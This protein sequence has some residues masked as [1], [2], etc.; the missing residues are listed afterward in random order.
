MLLQI[1][2]A[3]QVKRSTIIGTKH[4]IYELPYELQI[5]L[6]LWILKIREGQEN[7]KTP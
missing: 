2:L 7:P 3:P 5:D 1:L 6:R 4:G